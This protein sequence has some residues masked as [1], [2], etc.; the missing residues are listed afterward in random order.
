MTVMCKTKALFIL[1]NLKEIQEK[2][3]T[4]VSLIEWHDG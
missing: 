1:K 2:Y 4:V 3:L